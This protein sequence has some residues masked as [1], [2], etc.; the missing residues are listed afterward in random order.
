[1]SAFTITDTSQGTPGTLRISVASGTL[2]NSGVAL[3]GNLRL[4]KEG[5]GIFVPAKASQ[6]YTGGT[7]VSNGT[8]RINATVSGHFGTGAVTVPTDAV[9][10]VNGKD[11]TSVTMVLAGGTLQNSATSGA[12]LPKTLT[13][14]ADSRVVHAN[15]SSDTND[16]TVPNQC[17][18]NLGGKTLS[19]SMT[20]RDSDFNFLANGPN[21]VS[22]GTISVT[23]GTTS[24]S[25]KGYFAIRQINGKDGLRLDLGNTYLRMQDG[26]GNSSVMDFTANPVGDVYNQNNNRLQIYGTFTPKTATG[27]NMTMMGGSTLDLSQWAGAYNCA[28]PDNTYKKGSNQPCDLQFAAN[29]TI[30]VNL[31]GRTDLKTIA[32][33]ES[34][35]VVKWA[36]NAKPAATTT[37]DLDAETQE[38]GFKCKVEDTGLKLSR[39]KGMMLIVR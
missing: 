16:M 36:T 11:S 4:Q 35:Y 19:I 24:G 31:D 7:D 1:L 33:S 21:V 28:F 17:N 39:P 20:G 13:L 2:S 9:F 10:D 6:T 3:S 15:T 30:T 38:L 18:W 5:A 22:N 34:P 25:T 8:I 37:F 12:T 32:K 26:V 14:T 29:S 23:V 27:F